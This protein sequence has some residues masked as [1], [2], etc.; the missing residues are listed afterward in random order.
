MCKKT[1]GSNKDNT[2]SGSAASDPN[3]GPTHTEADRENSVD[4]T[5]TGKQVSSSP[6]STTGLPIPD[7]PLTADAKTS[8]SGS[9]AGSSSSCK[10]SSEPAATSHHSKKEQQQQ[11][12]PAGGL[13]KPKGSPKT[14]MTCEGTSDAANGVAVDADGGSPTANG[15]VTSGQADDKAVAE[16]V[17]VERPASSSVGQKV[18][19]EVVTFRKG[20]Q[21]EIASALNGITEPIALV[22]ADGG[23]I[24]VIGTEED[25]ILNPGRHN[26]T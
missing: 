1:K 26:Y 9:R 8:K 14:A 23:C 12:Q 20:C 22:N 17:H 15:S 4:T 19:S 11:Q 18:V 6:A 13:K 16:Q 10:G 5:K 3:N 25:L 21:N 24:S 7:D 2:K